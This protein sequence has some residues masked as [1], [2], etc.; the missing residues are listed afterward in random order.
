MAVDPV[1][2]TAFSPVLA[3]FA[4]V[5]LVLIADLVTKDAASNRK[6][7]V[8]ITSATLL[9]AILL[10][11]K[12]ND[13]IPSETVLPM[14]KFGI[15][16]QIFSIIGLSASIL[17]IFSA[18][19][20]FTVQKDLGVWASLLMISNAGGIVIA[21]SNHLLPLYVGFELM[22]IPIYGMVAYR[23][24]S[25]EAT[26]ASVKLF[27]LG[28]ISS[29]IIVYGISLVY[30]AT[31]QLTF[32]ALALNNSQP[33]KNVGIFLILFGTSFKLSLVPF[34]WWVSDV[35][36]G[37][38]V[39]MVNYLAVASKKMAFAFAFQMF[40][41]SFVNDTDV[42][43]PVMGLIVIL[44]IL[45]GN[46]MAAIQNRV[47]RLI[48]YSSI[49]HAGYIA[50]SLVAYAQ[51]TGLPNESELKALALYAAI[52]HIVANILMKGTLI[53]GALIVVN[54]FENDHMENFRGIY[55]KDKVVGTT[56]V[57]ALF[58]LIGIPPL[59]GF[60]S[61]YFLFIAVVN[62][63]TTL[64]WATAFVFAIG[65]AISVYYYIKLARVILDEPSNDI[66]LVPATPLKAL[67]V[68]L[69]VL[70]VFF[71]VIVFFI[72]PQDVFSTLF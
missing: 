35:Y 46:G 15:F 66:P 33:L 55:K 38:P 34:H 63:N 57:L 60:V 49:A 6:F 17:V 36:V 61:K 5:I 44:S 43:G 52:L 40:M 32:A 42:W 41:I 48:A 23:K 12:T 28:A 51:A 24:R 7:V 58:S 50:I 21:A 72:T 30:G 65:S 1:A 39:S 27:L 69:T 20:D 16:Y 47:M 64:A 25:R 45:V 53:A 10:V 11:A 68:L 71:S 14:F 18:A 9:L 67:M 13:L 26:E 56:M 3:L 2:F 19:Y 8:S 4:G 54:S 22:A 37:A 59:G 29:G 31:G 70:T 62:T